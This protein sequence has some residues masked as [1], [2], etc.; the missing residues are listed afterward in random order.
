MSD[1]FEV[2]EKEYYKHLK[3]LLKSSRDNAG[4]KNDIYQTIVDAP[5]YDPL[6]ATYLE[7]GIIVLLLVD[8]ESHSINRVALSNTVHAAGAIKTSEKLFREIK[9]PL[10]YEKNIISAA[11]IS[12]HGRHTEDWKDLFVPA[13]SA[14]SARF[15]QAGAGITWSL[16]EPFV[17]GN[18][19]AAVIFS[20]FNTPSS[21]KRTKHFTSTYTKMLAKLLASFDRD[22]M[23]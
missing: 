16:V 12:G 19:R 15:N 10:N 23:N 4:L 3:H 20:F 14:S 2:R 11:I 17:Y 9:I 6:V 1:G 18:H 21:V 7:L 22:Q 5:F 13:L 8:E